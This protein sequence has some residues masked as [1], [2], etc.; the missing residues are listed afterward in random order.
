MPERRFAAGRDF[1]CVGVSAT[2]QASALGGNRALLCPRVWWEMSLRSVVG[3]SSLNAVRGGCF[4]NL[5]V[6]RSTFYICGIPYNL[7]LSVRNSA[8]AGHPV[9]DD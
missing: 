7:D 2:V 9:F 8:V 1:N 6:S 4:P 3:G 5:C